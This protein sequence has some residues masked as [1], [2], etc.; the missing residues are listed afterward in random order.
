MVYI[1]Y[2]PMSQLSSFTFVGKKLDYNTNKLKI[3]YEP[4]IIN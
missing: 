3:S 4:K 1:V 2:S